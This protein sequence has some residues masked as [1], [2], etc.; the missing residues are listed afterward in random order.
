MPRHRILVGCLVAVLVVLAA[1]CAH[2]T[3]FYTYVASYGNDGGTCTVDAPCRSLTRALTQTSAGGELLILDTGDYDPV[4][5]TQS[6][7]ILTA[8]GVVA[9]IA[10]SSGDGITV[11]A[12]VSGRA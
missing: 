8:P 1:P 4:S 6:V 2:A 5:I 9:S 11:S 3:T 12:C 7:S 10:V